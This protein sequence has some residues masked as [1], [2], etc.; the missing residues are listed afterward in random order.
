MTEALFASC[1]DVVLTVDPGG[2]SNL[3]HCHSVED[4]LFV[5]VRGGC[6]LE[7]LHS[8]GTAES[9]P[10]HPGHVVSRP[11]GT[12]VSHTFGAGDDGLE[13]LAYG[14]RD[15]SDMCFYPRSGKIAF[16]GLDVVVRVQRVDYWDGEE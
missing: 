8:D 7:L 12:G 3:P 4:E 5:V 10:V 16:G 2:L 9:H 1:R 14:L 15:P 6:A 13:L 11:A